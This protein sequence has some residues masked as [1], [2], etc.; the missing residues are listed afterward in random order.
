MGDDMSDNKIFQRALQNFTF[1]V[2]SGGAIEHL[3]DC[4]YVPQEI[5]KMLDFPTPYA[6]VQEAYWKYL[7]KKKI[8]VRDQ[9]ELADRHSRTHFVTEYDEYG[10]KSFRQVVEYDEPEAGSVSEY[11]SC[12]FGIRMYRDAGS[13]AKFLEPLTEPQRLYMEGVPWERR[14]VWHLMDG[15]M[16]GIIETLRTKCG[17][18]G[19][20]VRAPR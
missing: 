6:R 20:I 11:V 13:Y 12:D 4:G 7:L 18:S 19:E 8:I 15:R 5:V 17:Y 9:S 2:A 16:T 3:A 10:H 1:D 14:V